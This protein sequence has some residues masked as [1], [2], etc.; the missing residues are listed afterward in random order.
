MAIA[1]WAK[2]PALI[3][4][5]PLVKLIVKSLAAEMVPTCSV[6]AVDTEISSVFGRSVSL[7]HNVVPASG[8]WVKTAIDILADDHRGCTHQAAPE[9]IGR[10]SVLSTPT[11]QIECAKK[12]TAST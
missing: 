4:K 5:R 9:S 7:G 3:A 12:I 8:N 6:G 11:G 10:R 2:M 1:I